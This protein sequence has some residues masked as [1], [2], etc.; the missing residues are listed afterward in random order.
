MKTSVKGFLIAYVLLYL[1]VAIA[2]NVKMGP[3]GMSSGYLDKYKAD[4]DRYL[5]ITKSDAYKLSQENAESNPPD[6]ALK[7]RIAFVE[8]HE[9]LAEFKSE[10]H[11]RSLY[12]G[13]FDVFNALMLIVLVGRFGAKPLLGLL[14]SMIAQVRET[15][16][17]AEQARS[18]ADGRLE[19]AESGLAGLDGERALLET[20]TNDQ[21]NQEL[22]KIAAQ[23]EQS[24]ALLQKE[25]EDRKRQE[26]LLAQRALKEALVEESMKILVERYAA[27]RSP[28]QESALIDQFAN[29]LGKRQ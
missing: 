13:L 11:R 27:T 29:Q 21:L 4:Y 7:E 5:E 16:E 26:E 25:T 15:I 6:D 9:G 19:L 23:S 28:E 2:M 20:E 3:P 12:G 24:A 10:Q 17:T 22:E 8:S 18:D 1:V 14:D